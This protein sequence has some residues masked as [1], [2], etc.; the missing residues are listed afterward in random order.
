MPFW[1]KRRRRPWFGRYYNRRRRTWPRRKRRRRFVPRR[2]R[3]RTNKRRRRRRKKVRRKKQTLTIKQW[4]PDSIQKCTIKGLGL[5]VMGAEGRQFSCFT[6]VKNKYWPP[7]VPSGGGFGCEQYTVKYLYEQ[8]QAGNNIWTK[9]NQYKDLIR[10]MRC[11]ITF[12]RAP[13]TDFIVSFSRQP[14]FELNKFTYPSCHPHQQLLAKHKKIIYSLQTKPN[15]RY[16]TSIVIKPPKQMLNKWFFTSNFC[17]FPLFLLKGAAM[18]LNYSYLG[19]CNANQLANIYNLNIQF[20]SHAGWAGTHAEQQPYKPY[21]A[22]PNTIYVKFKNKEQTE[23]LTG[24]NDSYASSVSYSKGW[25]QTKILQAE[26]IRSTQGTPTAT[27]AIAG[28]RYN[29]NKDPGTGNKIYLVSIFADTYKPPTTDKLLIIEDLPIWLALYGFTDYVR[30]VKTSDFLKQSL[31][32][33]QSDYIHCEPEIQ[34][35][36]TFIPID[37]WFIQGKGYKDLPITDFEKRNWYPSLQT[38]LE[39]INSLVETG[40]Y[41][42]KYSETRNSNWELKYTYS[43][44]FKFGGPQVH[45][46]QI[47]D[48]CTFPTYNVP[49]TISKGI[50][51]QN[52]EKQT[53]ESLLHAWDFRRGFVTEK[54][55]KRMCTNISTDTEFQPVTEGAPP[56][57]KKKIGCKLRHPQE[58]IQEIK[59]CLQSLCEESICQEIQTTEDLHLLIKQQQQ[60]Q[61]QLKFSILKLLS[62]LKT[63]QQM[64]QLQTGLLE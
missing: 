55:L 39:S 29:P 45:Q 17:K 61:Q 23:T 19:C 28:A 62:D 27:R 37:L 11:R 60:Q 48:P 4:Q 59:S 30:E 38:Q 15:G 36:K 2:R 58:K 25:F 46:P 35:C 21:N 12:F 54:A 40:P 56:P 14:P 63:K 9:S 64:L 47:N 32:V 31:L 18:Q 41:I 33:I 26:Q 5:L 1:W 16:K 34:S 10:Y 42:P 50:Q 22:A 52:P 44:F 7:K 51:I 49:D 20:Y 3:Y 43:F 53:T 24:M 57:K 13:E 6:S 8:Y